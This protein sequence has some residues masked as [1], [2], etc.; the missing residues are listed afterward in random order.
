MNLTPQIPLNLAMNQTVLQIARHYVK[1]D[2]PAG[3]AGR[4]GRASHAGGGAGLPTGR[5]TAHQPRAARPERAK[6]AE[7]ATPRYTGS[8]R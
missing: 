8:G 4:T 7:Q 3:R 1:G 6:P 5:R 2:N